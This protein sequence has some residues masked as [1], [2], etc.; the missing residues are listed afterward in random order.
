MVLEMCDSQ[1]KRGESERGK[2]RPKRTPGFLMSHGELK[3]TNV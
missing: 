3:K 2:N 1:K